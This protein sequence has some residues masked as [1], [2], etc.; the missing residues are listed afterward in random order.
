[1][2]S[3]HVVLRGGSRRGIRQASWAVS[4]KPLASLLIRGRPGPGS[5]G[6]RSEVGC[7]AEVAAWGRGFGG[8]APGLRGSY[9]RMGRMT[10]QGGAALYG[11][12]L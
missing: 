12:G 9:L 10:A 1:M 7:R 4:A 8:S 5:P 2:H 6:V 3:S 11:Q